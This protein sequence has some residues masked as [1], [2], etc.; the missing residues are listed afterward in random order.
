[1]YSKTLLTFLSVFLFASCADLGTES[2]DEV[3]NVKYILVEGAFYGIVADNGAHYDPINLPSEFKKDGMRVTFAAS[4][5][6]GAQS[7]RM[8]GQIVKI[9]WIKRVY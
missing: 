3:G 2:V 8:W 7:T 4:K 1:M 6:E 5:V 9:T